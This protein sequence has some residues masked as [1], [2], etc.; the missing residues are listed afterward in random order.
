MKEFL[1]KIRYLG[2]QEEQAH[3]EQRSIMLLNEITFVLLLFQILTYPEA[4][5]HLHYIKI[6]TIFGIQSF[7]IVPLILNNFNY[8]NAAK[9]Y[10]NII[11]TLAM[12]IFICLHGWELR[13]DYC[14]LV[15]TV[16]AILFFK[17]INHRVSLLILIIS[18]Y[19]FSI[20]YTNNYPALL[21]ENVSTWNSLVIFLAM[22]FSITFVIARF[23][24]DSESYQNN[25][26]NAL[27]ALQQEQAKIEVQNKELEGVNKDL[28]RFAY[29]SSHNLKTPIRTIRSFA[30]LIGRDLK[31][32]KQENLPEYL[33]FI[34]RGA[35]QM[36]LLVTDILEYSQFNQQKKIEVLE[37]DLNDIISF[38]HLQLQAFNNKKIQLEVLTL[39][40]IESNKTF[41]TA[42]F[43]NLIENGVKYNETQTVEIVI[44]YKD[45]GDKHLFLFKDNGI[46]IEAIY[47]DRIFEMFERLQ[48]DNKYVGSGVGLGMSKKLVEK[49][50]GRIWLDSALDQGSTFYVEL[51][52]KY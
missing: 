25:L 28:E 46:G 51:P 49:L 37:V 35:S 21:I 33:D 36:Q 6:I 32:G 13:G 15:F 17:K 23:V 40:I 27:D 30:D 48:T 1:F 26:T 18:C 24:K 14:Y 8:T 22:I 45:K 29:I 20:Y 7:T 42:I 38:I 47:F 52:K 31:K 19:F 39:P 16:T 41:I 12:T 44:S 50:G 4:I 3:D 9:W 43:L 2:V 5:Y 34:K 11:F 10:F